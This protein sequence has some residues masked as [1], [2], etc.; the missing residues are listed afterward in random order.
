M[1]TQKEVVVYQG[2]S[3]AIEFKGDFTKDTLWG[4]QAQIADLFRVDQS[5]VSRHI[6][7]IFQTDEV[8]KKSNM[9]KMHIPDSDKPTA[10]Y[11]L[12]VILS[13]GYR[14]NSKVAIDFRRWATKTLRQHMIEGY[15][16]NKKRISQNYQRFMGAISEI[17][18]LLP[19]GNLVKTDQVLELVNAFAQTWL[20]LEA[21]D[22]N[23]L[24]K[25]GSTKKQ[26]IVTAEELSDSL[27][28]LKKQL[29][30]KKQ[31]SK[32]FGAEQTDG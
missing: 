14:T 22:A 2:R 13:V 31:A 4:N 18:A 11:S 6:R 30:A 5:V 29:M 26:V 10:F 7:N 8:D 21:Y 17:R 19:V 3:G 15:T 27:V 20:S 9:Q 16:I 23:S 28:K 24:P 25:N 32:L 12:D 1:K